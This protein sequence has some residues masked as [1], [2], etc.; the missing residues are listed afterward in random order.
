MNDIK[1]RAWDKKEKRMYTMDNPTFFLGEGLD[2]YLTSLEWFLWTLHNHSEGGIEENRYEIMEYT[3]LEDKNKKG[4]FE[5]DIIKQWDRSFIV[6]F[7]DYGW[8][9]V[10]KD[11]FNFDTLKPIEKFNYSCEELYP[12]IN[13]DCEII[14]NI[15]KNL[16]LLK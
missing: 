16:E 4:I 3:G 13:G 8:G 15:Y 6:C 9:V 2:W 10:S 11:D 1:L 14:G 5:G 7:V 12:F